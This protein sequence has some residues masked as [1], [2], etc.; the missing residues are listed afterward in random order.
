M[1]NRGRLDD[2][3]REVLDHPIR[4]WDFGWLR[5][6]G[7]FDEGR[8][9]WRYLSLVAEA[10]R[11]SPDL[12]DLGTGGGEL[13][14]ALRPHPRRTVATESYGPNV[15]VAASRLTRL[16][17]SVVRTSPAD[18]NV[19]QE[20][21]TSRG[22]LPFRD[23]A[24]HL[25]VDRNEAFLAREVAR[26]LVPGGL[27]L[28]EQTGS[29]ELPE[30][31]RLLGLPLPAPDPLA[32]NLDEATRQLERVGLRAERSGEASWEMEFRDVGSLVGYLRAVP[33][34]APGFSVE[35]CRPRLEELQESLSREHPVRVPCEG[36]W[37]TARKGTTV[38]AD[39]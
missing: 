33:W 31:H 17:I 5:E 13:L 11:D 7:G 9:P 26:V 38:H 3:L 24:F 14:A 32:W 15:P 10:A 27:F 21:S 39:S 37:L 20:T 4:G 25:V 23:G 29:S 22:S 18:D 1:A 2:Q 16:G 28:T 34:A 6:R 12:L 8:V 19:L 30:F 35:R 36:F